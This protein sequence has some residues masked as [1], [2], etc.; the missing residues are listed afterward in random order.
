MPPDNRNMP[1]A[2]D[3]TTAVVRSD[4]Q[5]DACQAILYQRITTHGH[6]R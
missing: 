1:P 3:N 5:D 6:P 2:E 4:E